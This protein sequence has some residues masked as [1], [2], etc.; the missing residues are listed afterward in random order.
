MDNLGETAVKSPL[1]S[2]TLWGLVISWIGLK[3]NVV[4]ATYNIS[5]DQ[6]K[7]FTD[8]LMEGGLAMAAIGRAMASK[9]LGV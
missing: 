4:L 3:L 7:A 1:A 8:L 6:I 9:K 2:T 5:P